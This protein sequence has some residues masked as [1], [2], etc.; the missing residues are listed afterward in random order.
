MR[1]IALLMDG[2]KRWVTFAWSA[3]IL[4]RIRETD[5]KINL[6]IYNSSGNWSRD[7]AYNIGEYNIFRL[8]DLKDYD[9]IILDL[10][11][12]KQQDIRREIIERAAE[13]G[14][15][16]LSLSCELPGASYVGIDNYAAMRS[17]IAHLHEVH[18]CKSF[19]FVMGPEDNYESC[20]RE[21]GIRDYLK[22]HDISFSEE[23]FY[24]GDFD[25]GSGVTAFRRLY[26]LHGELPD[27]V[28]CVSDNVAVGVCETAESFGYHVPR[29]FR[30]TGFDNFD[31]ARYYT[32]RISTVEHIREDEG[33]LCTD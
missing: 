13:A 11:N 27:A 4:N 32:P 7:N 33:Y 30:M 6:Y 25:Y 9:G 22:E 3:G 31:K 24:H 19:W 5:E 20:H 16:V 2:W 15:P 14:V 18:G 10:N 8:P 21:L 17:V 28:V 29:D 12:I 1:R 23:D 26:Q